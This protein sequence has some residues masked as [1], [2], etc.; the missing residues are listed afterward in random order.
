MQGNPPPTDIPQYFGF[1]DYSY[2]AQIQGHVSS[3]KHT[4]KHNSNLVFDNTQISKK[5]RRKLKVCLHALKRIQNVKLTN[6]VQY[7]TLRS[8][9]EINDVARKAF[10]LK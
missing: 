3:F 6:N 4:F 9:T 5:W 2:E 1:V 8:K 10:N 7:T